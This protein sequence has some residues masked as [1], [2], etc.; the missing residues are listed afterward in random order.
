MCWMWLIQR[1]PKA[2]FAFNLSLL[3]SNLDENYLVEFSKKICYISI[4]N[5]EADYAYVMRTAKNEVSI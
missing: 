2:N 4:L 3:P 1:Y 5:W